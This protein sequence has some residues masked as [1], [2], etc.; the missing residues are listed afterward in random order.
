MG[1]KVVTYQQ[2]SMLE[3]LWIM[4]NKI[5]QNITNTCQLVARPLSCLDIGHNLILRPSL[6]L[7][8]W[9]IIKIW[10]EYSGRNLIWGGFMSSWRRRLYLLTLLYLTGD[11]SNRYSTCSG[12]S[13]WTLRK[14]LIWSLAFGNWWAVGSIISKYGE[15][16]SRKY[17]HAE[18]IC[19]GKTRVV[20]STRVPTKASDKVK[21][22]RQ[23]QLFIK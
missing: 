18:H 20:E 1:Q 6:K 17:I 19:V 22:V 7:K 11:I 5:S 10:L 14:T 21:Y 3:L 23:K 13:T 2:S 4:L 8:G 16:Y 15:A 9:H 12:T